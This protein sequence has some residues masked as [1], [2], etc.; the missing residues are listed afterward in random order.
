VILLD[1]PS[2]GIAQREAEALAPLL[3]RIGEGTGAALVVIEHDMPVLRAVAPRFVAMD[4]GRVIADGPAADVLADQAVVAAYL[5][6]TAAAIDRSAPGITL[7]PD[8]D[9]EPETEG[10]AVP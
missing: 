10:A 7:P 5:G 1:E 8:T 2:S 9:P 4:Q 6:T 3:R